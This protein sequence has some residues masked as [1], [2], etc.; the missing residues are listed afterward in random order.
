MVVDRTDEGYVLQP[1]DSTPEA[2][3]VFYSAERVFTYDMK[4]HL[5]GS[6]ESTDAE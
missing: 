2:G 5:D 4:Q 3:V 6:I 1:A